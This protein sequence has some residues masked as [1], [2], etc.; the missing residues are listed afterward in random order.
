M[1]MRLWLS[2]YLLLLPTFVLVG[3]FC[4]VPVLWAFSM[5]LYEFEV[6]GESRW[7]GLA[8]YREY[9][10]DPTLAGSFLNM[11]LL[12]IFGI[13]LNIVTPLLVARLIFSLP[14][15]R[16]RHIY[17]TL[18]L[19]PIVVPGIATQL[20]WGGGIL[21]EFGMINGLLGMVG[22]EAWQRT[23]LIDPDTALA[24]LAVIGFPF[25]SGINILIFTA[26]L[27][28]I[29]TSLREAAVLEG[30]SPLRLFLHIE[31]PLLLSQV[32]LLTVLMTIGA[33]QNFEGILVLTGGGPGFETMVP[34]LWMY[35][36]AF[37]FQR[38]GLAAAIGVV[39]FVVIMVVTFL[40]FYFIKS[41]EAVQ[42]ERP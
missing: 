36:N 19:V 3:V 9:L 11:A 10:A 32:R 33:I 39:L 41:S 16:A 13:V 31:L 12:G 24:A 38:M 7:V 25:A 34:G 18:F 23:W 1:K 26:G 17:R 30:A 2:C 4:F 22:L 6:G 37:S 40:N 35:Y 5:S 8:N 27:A 28:A 14:G 21:G 42:G 29:P 15:E 20:I